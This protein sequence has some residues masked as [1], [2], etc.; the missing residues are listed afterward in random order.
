MFLKDCIIIIEMNF[1]N[2]KENIL[3][4]CLSKFHYFKYTSIFQN[5]LFN[6]F[7]KQFVF[8]NYWPF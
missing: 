4:Y 8:R 5:A 2:I 1:H 3:Y 7:S 6:I